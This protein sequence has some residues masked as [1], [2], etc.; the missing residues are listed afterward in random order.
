MR[1][2]I[3]DHA[4]ELGSEFH[5]TTLSLDDVRKATSC[6]ICNSVTGVVPVQ[7]VVFNE[8]GG[9]TPQAD[10]HFDVQLAYQLSQ[11]VRQILV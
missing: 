4:E 9:A 7:S 3:L 6:F 1:Q 2:W 8:H 10:K 11:Q 5:E